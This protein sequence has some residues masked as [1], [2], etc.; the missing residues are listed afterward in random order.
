[1]H[2]LLLS[3]VAPQ[4]QA[5]VTFRSPIQPVNLRSRRVLSVQ[6]AL[7]GDVNDPEKSKQNKEKKVHNITALR[8]LTKT[9]KDCSGCAMHVHAVP[10]EL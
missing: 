10:C 7:I 3:P 1:M 4:R 5:G 9:V 2:S 6:R 8:S